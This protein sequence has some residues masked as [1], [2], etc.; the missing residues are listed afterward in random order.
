M[1]GEFAALGTAICWALA[2]ILYKGA[3]LKADPLSANILRC[4]CA[5]AVLGAFIL[6]TGKLGVL[7]S[8]PTYMFA[9]ACISGIISLGIGDTFYL[10]SLRLIGVA[11]AVPI[12]CTYPL[13]NL[14]LAVFLARENV[15]LFIVLGASAIVLGIWFISREKEANVA[16]RQKQILLKGVICA[17]SSAIMWSIGISVANMAVRE[18]PNFDYALA[19]NALRVIAAVVFLL[20]LAPIINRSFNFLEI[21]REAFIELVAGGVMALVIGWFLFILSFINTSESRAV[22]LSSTGALFS[23][24]AGIVFLRE[25]VTTENVMGSLFIVAGIFLIFLA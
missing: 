9:L 13:F 21:R 11:R 17:L 10:I 22:P 5:S 3:L 8:M 12:A 19:I 18:A 7:K 4:L 23:T 25:K 16:G 6:G 14:L 24:I 2:A 15:T 20:F 1:I